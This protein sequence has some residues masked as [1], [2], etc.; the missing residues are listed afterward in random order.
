MKITI[1]TEIR[2]AYTCVNCNS[3]FFLFSLLSKHLR[4]NHKILKE[5]IKRIEKDTYIN[6]KIFSQLFEVE[7]G[8]TK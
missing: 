4:R 3:K 2:V 8:H 7:T 1:E 5:E 6:D